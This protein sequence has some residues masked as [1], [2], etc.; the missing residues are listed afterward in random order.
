[1][2]FKLSDPRNTRSRQLLVLAALFVVLAAVNAGMAIREPVAWQ[3]IIAGICAGMAAVLVHR[4]R[5]EE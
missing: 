3:W 4:R 2:R 5:Q 1:M